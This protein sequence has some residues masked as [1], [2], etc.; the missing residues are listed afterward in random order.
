MRD[1]P[2]V[3]GSRSGPGE[4]ARA[5]ALRGRSLRIDYLADQP[6]TL[7]E[8]AG[9]HHAEFGYL[10]PTHSAQHYVDR[11]TGSLQTDDLPLTVVAL[12]S[13]R[14]LGSATLNR[15][16]ITHPHLSPWLSSVFVSA[17]ER[18][19]GIASALIGRIEEAS[20]LGFD[21]AHLF[22]PKSEALYARLGWQ[23]LERAIVRDTAVTIM[24]KVLR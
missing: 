10:N 11:L 15:Q 12:E 20:R 21:T 1:R 22:T 2:V 8:L 14:L 17:E 13:G 23:T 19:R 9:W 5:A 6:Q 18:G 7:P 4:T 16:T 3:R 24:R